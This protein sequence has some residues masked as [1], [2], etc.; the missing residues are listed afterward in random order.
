[1]SINILHK[2]DDDDDDDDNNN[3]NNNGRANK[4]L[5][6]TLFWDFMCCV[7]LEKTSDLIYTAAEASNPQ[8]NGS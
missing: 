6:S 5:V 4:Y 3:N 2:G 1:M 7:N 8:G